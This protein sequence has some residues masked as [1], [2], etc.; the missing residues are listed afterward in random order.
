M[1]KFFSIF[2]VVVTSSF[3]P[4]KGLNASNERVEF[5]IAPGFASILLQIASPTAAAAAAE[6]GSLVL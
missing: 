3:S 2:R 4:F 5:A 1:P 6:P